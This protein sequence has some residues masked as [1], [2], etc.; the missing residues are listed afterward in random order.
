MKPRK[1]ISTKERARLF[2]LHGGV[3]HICGIKI[4]GV[5]EKWDVEHVLA[6]ELGGEDDDWNRKPAH[7]LCHK[8]KTADD[9]RMIR[10][11]DR[12]RAKHLGTKAPSRTPLP[13]GKASKLKRKLDGTVVER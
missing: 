3:C 11:S 10:K 4:D 13:F 12:V 9:I 2:M 1:H 7:F 6:L 8:P 5:R